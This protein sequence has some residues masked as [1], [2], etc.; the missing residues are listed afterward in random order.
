MIHLFISLGDVSLMIDEPWIKLLINILT[1]AGFICW[2]LSLCVKVVT[3]LCQRT[4][5]TSCFYMG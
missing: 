1:F 3:E 4:Q 2:N 5:T